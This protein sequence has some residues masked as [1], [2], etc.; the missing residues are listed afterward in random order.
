M[1]PS[2]AR[3]A[4]RRAEQFERILLKVNTNGSQVLLR[5]VARIELGAENYSVS[6][7]YN[8]QPAAGLAI[9]LAP[10][11]QCP[12]YREGD[13]PTI[14]QLKPFF[15][16]GLEG[17]LPFDTTPFVRISIEE[18]VKTLFE[19]IVLVFIVMYVFL[20]N[21]RATL[22]PTIAVPVVLLGTFGILSVA[23]F[24]INT[25]T[26][27]GMV[28]AIGLLVDDAIVVVEN[29][30][31]VMEEEKLSPRDAARKSMGQITGALVGIALVL[32]AVFLPMA[33]FS[34][35][36]GVIYRQ[37]SIT[38]VSAMAL[39]VVVALIL[40]PALCATLLKAARGWREQ[41]SRRLLR[42]V[43]PQL[44]PRESRL[45]QCREPHDEEDRA[46]PD[47]LRRDRGSDGRA[48]LA[49]SQVVPAR[50]GSGR[51]VLP[52]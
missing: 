33:F 51:D 13:Q 43:Q 52:R 32:S 49:D 31:R 9:K 36:T 30:E 8:G 10:G 5:D 27:F 12:G 40:T 34:G 25:L 45:R 41:A 42:L 50:R 7:K 29:V 11:C 4:C 15:P 20:Q 38:I 18:V 39:S 47:C 21:F 35:S 6:T 14:E 44:R 19:A 48:V 46:L 2:S 16:P 3:S 37:F 17:G 24:S 1:P 26:M 23:G 22:I 28:L